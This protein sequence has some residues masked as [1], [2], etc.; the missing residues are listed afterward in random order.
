V[1]KNL[2]GKNISELPGKAVKSRLLL[3]ARYIA[4]VQA[5]ES[6]LD[7]VDPATTTGNCLP[8]DGTSKYHQHYQG[9][10]LTAANGKTM[11]LSMGE[12]GGSTTADIIKMFTATL[13]EL[14]ST[15]AVEDDARERK[16]QELTCSIKNT[17]SDQG[18][19]N[20]CFNEQLAALRQAA[21]PTVV[22]NWD[23]LMDATYQN[24]NFRYG[25]LF[26]QDAPPC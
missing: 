19:I 12:M 26:L 7:G 16:V 15:V 23:Q 18:S 25:Q 8:A 2:G 5:A 6:M 20:P 1:L 9:F 14:A 10:Q 21:L 17:M 24:L 13:D 11:T 4:Q 3:E 22:Q